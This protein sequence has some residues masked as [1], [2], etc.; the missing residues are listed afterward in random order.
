VV[1]A[2]AR[3]YGA[4][5]N[6]LEFRGDHSALP[7]F[8]ITPAIAAVNVPK[9]AID[10]VEDGLD[11]AALEAKAIAFVAQYEA[12]S[13]PPRFMS[14]LEKPSVR[15][16]LN[17]INGRQLHDAIANEKEYLLVT[18][19]RQ[20]KKGWS[21]V[22]PT[23]EALAVLLSDVPQVT[24]GSF[25]LANNAHDA[26]AFPQ[27]GIEDT[28]HIFLVGGGRVQKYHG[29][30]TQVP[31]AYFVSRKVP[32]DEDAAAALEVRVQ[33]TIQDRRNE[34]AELDKEEG[35]FYEMTKDMKKENVTTDFAII[36]YTEKESSGKQ[37]KKGDTVTV[38]YTGFLPGNKRFTKEGTEKEFVAGERGSVVVC[39]SHVVQFMQSG[40]KAY[41]EC[42]AALVYGDKG[43]A[44]GTEDAEVTVPLYTPVRYHVEIVS[45]VSVEAKEEL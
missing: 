43:A 32:M 36:K 28:W 20:A 18:F 40:E 12:G 25:D 8:G 9:Y 13:L 4:G 2:D 7:V 33:R 5:L 30:L 17:E 10:T 27:P 24:V 38:K 6:T 22:R 23:F 15:G 3:K 19:F 29:P 35:L 14:T 21:I 31:L 45:V 41:V 37:V 39:L 26:N 16:Q 11:D 34:R 42:A 44:A 1:Q